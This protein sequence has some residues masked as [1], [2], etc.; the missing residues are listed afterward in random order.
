MFVHDLKGRFVDVNRRACESLGYDREEL[1]SMSVPE[2]EVGVG[3][4]KLEEV[5]EKVA[6]GETITVEGVHRRK[7]GSEFPVEVR[8][9]AFGHEG[10]PLML[11]LARDITERKEAERELY[12]SHTLLSSVIEGT[13]DAIFMK[14]GAGRYVLVNSRTASIFGEP[15]EEVVGKTDADLLPPEAAGSLVEADARVL[16]TG[17][18]ITLE[19]VVPVAG[20]ERSFLVSKSAYRDHE[21]EVAGVI[22]VATDVT[23]IKRTEKALKQSE[24][25]YRTVVEQA[26]ETIFLVDVQTRR[27]IQANLAFHDLLGYTPEDL[28]TLTLYDIVAHDRVSIDRITE[29]ILREGRYRVGERLYLCKDGTF[30]DVEVSAAALSYGD[31]DVMCVVA[32]DITE[33]KQTEEALSEVRE[34]E[35]RRI[36]RDLHD[37]SLQHIASALQMMQATQIEEGFDEDSELAQQIS[38]LREAVRGLRGAIYDLRLEGRRSFFRSIESLVELNRQL[39]PEREVRLAVSGS[40]P[41]DLPEKVKTQLTRVVQEALTNVRKHSEARTVTVSL[42]CEDG[43]IEVEVA[44][45]GRGFDASEAPSGYGVPG[46][47]ERLREIGGELSVESGPGEGARLS[48]RAPFTDPPGPR[49]LRG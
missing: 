13:D 31:T 6:S 37:L 41:E 27:I 5:W 24:E 26:A 49:A 42:D 46:M 19:E 34:A 28:E 35:R 23:E 12:E 18:S 16:A 20:A 7:D 17:E 40:C 33:R 3:L 32:H 44:D 25:L 38:A 11:A 47:R 45:D 9:G 39:A 1:L 14:D 2:V 10:Q 36:A 15:V 4:P 29:R 21:G 30:L 22:G 48:F 43:W 8:V